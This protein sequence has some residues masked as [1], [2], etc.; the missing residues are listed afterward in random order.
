MAKIPLK[1][2]DVIDSGTLR[3]KL[4][5]LTDKGGAKSADTRAKALAILK[6]TLAAGRQAGEKLLVEDGSGTACAGKG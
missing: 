2:E 5:A 3:E 1:L 4:G 6:E